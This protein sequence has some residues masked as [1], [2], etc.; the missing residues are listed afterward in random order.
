MN[1][2]QTKIAILARGC[3]RGQAVEDSIS[4]QSKSRIRLG[5][6]VLLLMILGAGCIGG[7]PQADAPTTSSDG[8]ERPAACSGNETSPGF[9]L[10]NGTLPKRAGGFE[11]GANRSVVPRGEPIGFTLRNVGI[12]RRYSGTKAKYLLQRRSGDDWETVTL[13]REPHL[14]FNATAIVH[15]PGEGFEWSFEA[16]AHGL[17][18][19]KYAVCQQLQSGEY[20]FVYVDD[21]PVA[22]RFEVE[23]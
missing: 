18:D 10:P 8:F 2:P 6:L 5:V 21:S 17:T 16:S 1:P 19:G 11:L 12:E 3:L 23:G 4:M 20:R 22:V 9:D 7:S 15:E 14:G 13:L